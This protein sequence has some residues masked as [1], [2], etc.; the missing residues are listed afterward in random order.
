MIILCR[1]PVTLVARWEILIPRNTFKV[2]G[3]GVIDLILKLLPSNSFV[4]LSL[5]ISYLRVQVLAQ[6]H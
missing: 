3:F 1:L 6:D 5:I 4:P 2:P